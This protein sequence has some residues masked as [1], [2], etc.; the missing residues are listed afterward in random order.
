MRISPED[1]ST[2]GQNINTTLHEFIPLWTYLVTHAISN[3]SV[4]FL[5][6]KLSCKIILTFYRVTKHIAWVD[7]LIN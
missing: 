1:G 7:I 5:Q 6:L 3:K 2:W 4:E